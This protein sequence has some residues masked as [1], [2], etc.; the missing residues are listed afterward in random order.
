MSVKLM[1]NYTRI[2]HVNNSSMRNALCE[3]IM[4]NICGNITELT[5]PKIVKLMLNYT[6]SLR[7]NNISIQNALCEN[8][9]ANICGNILEL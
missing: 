8:I 3:N 1:L 6:R 9:K 7:V 5:Y 2:L 4:E